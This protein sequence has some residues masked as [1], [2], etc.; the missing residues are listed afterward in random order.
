MGYDPEKDSYVLSVY[1]LDDRTYDP[2]QDPSSPGET[3]GGGDGGV[4]GGNGGGP[5]IVTNTYKHYCEYV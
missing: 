5:T 3:G 4:A 2:V 1:N